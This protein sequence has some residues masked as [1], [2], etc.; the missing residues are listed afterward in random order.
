MGLFG[1]ASFSAEQRTKEI[2]I[3]KILGASVTNLILLLSREFIK[4]V[5]IAFVLAIPLA[6][7]F[8]TMWLNAFAY[9]INIGLEVF[10]FAGGASFIIAWLT[11]SYQALKVASANPV[12]ALRNE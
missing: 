10:V 7:Y 5:V 3:R 4:L 8:T 11:V 12:D 6:Y 1:L 9:R 2:G